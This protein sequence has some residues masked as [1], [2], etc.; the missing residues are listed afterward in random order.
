MREWGPPFIFV[1]ENP[2]LLHAAGLPES[3]ADIKNARDAMSGLL[4]DRAATP[5]SNQGIHCA[6]SCSALASTSLLMLRSGA[7]EGAAAAL[8][9]DAAASANIKNTGKER[10]ITRNAKGVCPGV[11]ARNQ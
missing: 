3:R 9:G 2:T 7:G 6:T 5:R 11:R 8:K 1:T 10:G 4:E